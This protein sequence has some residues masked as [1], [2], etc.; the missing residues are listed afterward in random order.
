MKSTRSTTRHTDQATDHD[1]EL[2]RTLRDALA[3]A[4]G[5]RVARQTLRHAHTKAHRRLG[6]PLHVAGY[7]SLVG[8]I[9]YQWL[10]RHRS[11]A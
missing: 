6:P 2:V 7:A 8:L 5:E 1:L 4:A 9:G 11:A 3:L 10:A